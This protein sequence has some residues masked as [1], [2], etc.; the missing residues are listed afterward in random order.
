[1]GT[2]GICAIRIKIAQMGLY[3]V[4]S[5]FRS[6]LLKILVKIIALPKSKMF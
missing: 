5:M 6:F 1:M 3:Y 2:K 4:Y